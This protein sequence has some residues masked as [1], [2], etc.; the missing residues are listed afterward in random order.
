MRVLFLGLLLFI[1]A[2]ALPL[3]E[4]LVKGEVKVLEFANPSLLTLNN[5]KLSFFAN[6]S[7]KGFFLCV[8]AM[9][10][11]HAK[12]LLLNA[13]FK[14][15]IH[16]ISI[17]FIPLPGKYKQE[18]IKV[19]KNK[20]KYNKKTLAR[21]KKEIKEVHKIY[22]SSLK[23]IQFKTKFILP[24][25]SKTTSRFGNARVFNN[26]LHSFHSG[27]DFR[28]AIGSKVRA[29]NDGVVRLVQKRFF[30]GSSIIIDH[31]KG[32]F[33]QYYH[34]SKFLVKL[35]QRV[36]KGD[37]IALSGKSGR[38]NGPHLHFGIRV[39]NIQVNP[40]QFIN[41]INRYLK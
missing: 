28:A 9:P 27:V 2:N 13:S 38:A 18:A 17:L 20:I 8:V 35:N 11:L 25:R 37:I 34:L 32:I 15:P 6:P 30:A 24:I 4:H 16:E 7:K 36:K 21:I 12:R 26:K 5:K 22:S 10:Y 19:N 31:G 29:S 41:Q 40:K 23:Q 14:Q 1:F 3:K 33:T 39:N